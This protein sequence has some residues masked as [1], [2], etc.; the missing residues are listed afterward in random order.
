MPESQFTEEPGT[1]HYGRWWH[2]WIERF[3]WQAT[4]QLQEEYS[5]SIESN[6]PFA[7]R[8]RRE[9]AVFLCS[10]EISEIMSAGEW[11]RSEIS[12]SF[13]SAES[14]WVEGVID[15]VVG[16]RSK[17]VWVIDWKTNQKQGQETDA[18]FAAD[19]GEKYLPQLESYRG[20][21]EQGF[22]IPVTRVLIYSTVLGRFV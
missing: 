7:G 10:P 22:K 2:L 1:Y 15:L 19:L 4:R 13:P 6:L 8:A 5:R 17:E 18:A 14:Q 16:T 3:P 21:I 9:T 11:F 20:V 12:F